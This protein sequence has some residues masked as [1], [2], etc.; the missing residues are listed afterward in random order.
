MELPSTTRSPRCLPNH[1][2]CKPINKTKHTGD[3]KRIKYNMVLLICLLC[4]GASSQQ[5]TVKLDVNYKAAMPLGN[6]KNITDK[7]SLNGWEAALMYSLTNQIAVGMQTGFQD[8]YQKYGR[9]VFHSGGSDLSAVVTN[10]V[11]VMPV[12]LKGKYKFT[13]AGLVQPFVALGV[14]GNLVQYRKYYGQFT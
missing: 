6:F 13:D 14:G 11:Q 5:G 4:L 10:S 2:I 7:T 3:M 1:R 8:F 12:L 9:Q